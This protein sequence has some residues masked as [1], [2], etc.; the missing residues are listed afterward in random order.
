MTILTLFPENLIKVFDC[1]AAPPAFIFSAAT[2]K[3]LI[4]EF[5]SIIQKART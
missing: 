1:S 2:R 5:F 4:D 3:K